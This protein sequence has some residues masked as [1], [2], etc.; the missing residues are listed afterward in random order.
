ALRLTPRSLTDLKPSTGPDGGI[1]FDL[2]DV[3]L[4]EVLLISRRREVL[5]GV[6]NRWQ[7]FTERLAA[8]DKISF[9][10]Y[11]AERKRAA[12]A[13]KKREV[14]ERRALFEKYATLSAWRVAASE[15]LG[16][17]GVTAPEL[18]NPTG[19]KYN[20]RTWWAARGKHKPEDIKGLRW[21]APRSGPV[22]VAINYVP[23]NRYRLRLRDSD[24]KLLREDILPER[25]PSRSTVTQ[26][27]VDLPEDA[28]VEFVEL[29]RDAAGGEMWGRVSPQA[30]FLPAQ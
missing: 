23:H 6:R 29:G 20:A 10:E 26:W 30:Y 4:A 1:V 13:R 17:Y 8:V 22:V 11:A 2:T 18:W 3:R 7:G 19:E 25:Y 27:K 16:A 12:A 5:E 24:G 14:T 9:A 21:K 28:A 15:A